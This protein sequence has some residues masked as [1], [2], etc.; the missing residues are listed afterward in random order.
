MNTKISKEQMSEHDDLYIVKVSGSCFQVHRK[1]T[2]PHTPIS[3]IAFFGYNFQVVSFTNT[4]QH[5]PITLTITLLKTQKICITKDC[6]SHKL[7]E[8]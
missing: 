2:A 1:T 5:G 8:E 3:F 6:S 7:V 4:L